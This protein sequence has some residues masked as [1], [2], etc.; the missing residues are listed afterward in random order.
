MNHRILMATVLFGIWGWSVRQSPLPVTT[1]LPAGGGAVVIGDL[2]K[3]QNPDI[4]AAGNRGLTVYL[5]DGRLGFR[6]TSKSPYAAGDNPSD[7]ALGDFN[8][9]G[10]LDIAVAN[11]ETNYL[12]LL[13]GGG[14]GGLVPASRSRIS[15]RSRPHPHGVA[16]G[17]FNS[18]RHLDLAVESWAENTVLVFH[19][20][21]KGSF[22]KE[23]RLLGVG[24]NPYYK[25]RAADLN[26]DGREDLITTNTDG[27]SVSVSCTEAGVLRPAKEIATPR[28][29]F[30]VAIGDVNGD[31]YPDLAVAH[32]WGAVDPKLDGLT[33]LLGHGECVF[34]PTSESPMKIGTSPT[35]VAIGDIDGDGIGDIATA[36]MES[37]D[38]TVVLGSRSGVQPAKWSPVSVG[39]K[40]AAI[41]FGDLNGDG[42]ADIVTGNLGSGDL[43]VVVSR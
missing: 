21:G 39:K 38:V 30:A 14:K 42:K 25:L 11:H 22:A 4:I 9:D 8:E 35:A 41:A 33:V 7:L 3:D 23:P 2:N 31:R 32:R 40:P 24:R 1:T 28:F 16:A 26:S 18:D 15:V 37:N 19:G 13:L 6:Q 36:N 5:G 12:T 29:P 10:W 43:S 34:T 27:S 20:N 17:D